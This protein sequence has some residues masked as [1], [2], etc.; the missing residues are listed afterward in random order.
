M[1]REEVL[2]E[3]GLDKM[4]APRT[5]VPQEHAPIMG[6]SLLNYRKALQT[7]DVLETAAFEP[8]IPLDVEIDAS[9]DP[10]A[11]H[12]ELSKAIMFRTDVPIPSNDRVL[13]ATG[14]GAEQTPHN[15][16]KWLAQSFRRFY[17][18]LGVRALSRPLVFRWGSATPPMFGCIL[19]IDPRKRYE[20]A[21]ANWALLGEKRTTQVVA[22][23]EEE[24]KL[25]GLKKS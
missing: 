14:I 15:Q 5:E 17:D 2:K 7:V 19:K 6:H 3:L 10:T 9:I 4:P 13:K 23:N 22:E 11:F 18:E 1:T 20:N 25:L 24:E 16:R 8:Y 12:P 21:G